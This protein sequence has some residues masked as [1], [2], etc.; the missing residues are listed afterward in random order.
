MVP[1]TGFS[2]KAGTPCATAACRSAAWVSVAAAMTTPSTPAPSSS[3]GESTARAEGTRAVTASTAAV[4]GSVR[5][6][7]STWSREASVSAWKAPMRPRPMS[8]MRTSVLPSDDLLVPVDDGAGDDARTV[9]E[10]EDDRVRDLVG[11]AK[12][13]HRQ[14]GTGLLDPVVAGVVEA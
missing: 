7:S 3:S 5:T 1:A 9:G 6:S 11:L 13:T 12:S 8:P 14:P 10:E 2:Q 4:T